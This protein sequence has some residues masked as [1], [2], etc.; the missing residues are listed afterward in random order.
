ME[1]QTQSSDSRNFLAPTG[2]TLVVPKPQERSG[3]FVLP[4]QQA[5]AAEVFTAQHSGREYLGQQE[6]VAPPRRRA[7]SP[8]KLPERTQTG[9]LYRGSLLREL[10]K[11]RGLETK[12]VSDK[13]GYH[14]PRNLKLIEGNRTN[15]STTKLDELAKLLD[16]PVAELQQAP[17]HPRISRKGHLEKPPER[18]PSGELY[19]GSLIRQLREARGLK[20]KALEAQLGFSRNTLST[21]ELN[22]GNLSQGRLHKLAELLDVPVTELEQAPVYPVATARRKA[23]AQLNH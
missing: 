2:E 3:V 17:V 12:E 20:M 15:P 11:A 16:V 22:R 9:E 4:A 5:E 18:A 13:L 1:R 19:R 23:K 10:R 14:H 8:Q 6:S 7:G 21:I